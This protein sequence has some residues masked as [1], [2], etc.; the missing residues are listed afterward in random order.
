[1]S[2]AIIVDTDILIDAGHD[3]EVALSVLEKYE[4]NVNLS[5]S[6][7][8]KMELVVGSRLSHKNLAYFL[9]YIRNCYL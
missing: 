5:V 6:V 1:M 3:I 4:H 8:T 7:I 9:I 2:G